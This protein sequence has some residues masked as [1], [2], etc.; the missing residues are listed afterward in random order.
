VKYYR[1][2]L[3]RQNI[4]NW[5]FDLGWNSAQY[6]FENILA[7]IPLTEKIGLGIGY[8]QKLNPFIENSGRAIT[9]SS[10]INQVTDGTVYA[11]TVASGVTITKNILLGISLVRYT[12][13]VTS[14]LQGDNHGRELY[15]SAKLESALKGVNLNLGMI[16]KTENFSAGATFTPPF[17]LT[18]GAQKQISEENSYASLFPDYD[19]AKWK[20][21][22]IGRIGF[23]YA[24]YENWTFAFDL[25]TH[26]YESS[27][28]RLNLVEFGGAPNWKDSNILRAGIEFYPFRRPRWPVRLGYAY[29]P[30]LYASNK[31]IGE[32][33]NILSYENT[34]QN[35]KQLFT[36]GTTLSYTN[37]TLNFGLEYAWLKWH[38]DLQ[39]LDSIVDDYKEKNYVVAAEL[40]YSFSK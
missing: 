12:G 33:N 4:G 37:F 29:I 15:K 25:E 2:T 30:Q 39:T 14:R 5:A 17:E 34:K 28:V 36:A 10:L 20:M 32:G 8:M 9:G 1:Y 3:F 22:W 38:R 26:H 31:A 24:G 16:F 35:V 18:V 21:P 13:N 40:I 6:N 23:A 7:A 11:L 27:E 19:Q